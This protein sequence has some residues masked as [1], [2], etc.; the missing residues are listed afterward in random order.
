MRKF[1]LFGALAMLASPA[2]AQT[3]ELN[4]LAPGVVYN[5]G[6]LDLA[7]AYTRD[8]GI[9]VTVKSDGMAAI[10]NDIKKGTP[11]ADV[12]ALPFAFMDGMEAEST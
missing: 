1:L 11:V 6:L 9:K 10:V 3:T 12:I 2:L 8:T 4:V 7:A 5:A